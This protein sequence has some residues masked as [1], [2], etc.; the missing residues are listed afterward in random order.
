MLLFYTQTQVA[1]KSHKL[2][3]IRILNTRDEKS[4]FLFTAANRYFNND[5]NGYGHYTTCV[6]CIC[7]RFFYK[8]NTRI[9]EN[10]KLFLIEIN[11]NI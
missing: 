8:K 2:T 7:T 11:K 5:R 10:L 4:S 6:F 1:L 3:P 9:V